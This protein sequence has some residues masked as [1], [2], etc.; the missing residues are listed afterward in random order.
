M[1]GVTVIDR[2]KRIGHPSE[3]EKKANFAVMAPGHD[4]CGIIR[5]QHNL[6]LFV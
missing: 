1:F 6:S 5:I 3:T 4:G 2:E